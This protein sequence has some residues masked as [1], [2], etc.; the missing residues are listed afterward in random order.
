M[1]LWSSRR[2]FEE[3]NLSFMLSKKFISEQGTTGVEKSL[4]GSANHISLRTTSLDFKPFVRFKEEKYSS[5]LTQLLGVKKIFLVKT[6]ELS[7][8]FTLD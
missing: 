8:F 6:Y 4:E 2:L 1:L 7:F 3:M 5:L